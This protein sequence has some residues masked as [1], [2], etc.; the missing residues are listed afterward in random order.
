M[1]NLITPG[2]ESADDPATTSAADRRGGARCPCLSA[3]VVRVLVRPSFQ[4]LHAVPRDVGRQ[5]LCLYVPGALAVGSR[6]ALHAPGRRPGESC[7]LSGHVVHATCRD[8][9]WR[10]GCALSRPLTDDE[11]EALL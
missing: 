3:A 4:R 7:I 6:L 1:E 9:A 2:R 10:V 8:R 5:G 11:L